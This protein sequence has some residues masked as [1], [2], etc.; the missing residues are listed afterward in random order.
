MKTNPFPENSD[1]WA[2][3]DMLVYRDIKAFLAA[4]WAMVADDFIEENFMGIDG[5]KV[6]NPDGW[7]MGFPDL[8]SY[9]DEWLRQ[10]RE[11]AAMDWGEDLEAAF[12]RTTHL[13]DIDI[14]GDSALVHK[15][16]IGNITMAEKSMEA[17][18]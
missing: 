11:T 5:G 3:W 13:R 17:G 15:K 1:R 16:F 10:A 7:T 14:V 18:K 4:D 12:F 2:I 6:G 8:K 9:R